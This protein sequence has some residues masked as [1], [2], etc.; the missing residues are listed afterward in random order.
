MRWQR[1]RLRS[2]PLCLHQVSHLGVLRNTG[3]EPQGRRCPPWRCPPC[4]PPQRLRS[5]ETEELERLFLIS[6]LVE[7]ERG[8]GGGGRKHSSSSSSSKK[9]PSSSSKAASSKGE[10]KG[11]NV[12]RSPHQSPAHSS[13]GSASLMT[14][15]SLPGQAS[16]SDRDI[17]PLGISAY[18]KSAIS[19]ISLH[20]QAEI[21]MDRRARLVNHLRLCSRACG[22]RS[23]RI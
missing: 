12:D 19:R 22:T 1:W 11:G 8:E 2:R 14:Q 6:Q 21:H 18:L 4:P 16:R 23:E 20:I 13:S 7:Q 17:P 5:R 10:R 9:R 15:P 3:A